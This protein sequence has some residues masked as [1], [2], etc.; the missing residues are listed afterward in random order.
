[1]R[2]LLDTCVLSE[3]RKPDCNPNV[4]FAISNCSNKDLFIS[5]ISIGEIT[6]GVSLLEEGRRKKELSNWLN[7]L[8]S[9]FADRILSVDA[10]TARIWGE[11]TADGK[12]KGKP[13]P[14]MDGLI[15]ATAIRSGLHV[16]TRNIQDFEN[17]SAMLFNPWES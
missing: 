16:M 13:I 2:F 17:T 5:S 3:L 11:L 14:I 8:E 1:M 6:K 10:E 12:R 15:A 4:K 9:Q 7:S